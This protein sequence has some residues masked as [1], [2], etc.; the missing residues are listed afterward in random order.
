MREDQ[1]NSILRLFRSCDVT[2]IA[3]TI[4][5]ER[6]DNASKVATRRRVS[7]KGVYVDMRCLGNRSRD[8]HTT[9]ATEYNKYVICK[10]NMIIFISPQYCSSKIKIKTKTTPNIYRYRPT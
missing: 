6:C 8:K 7:L 4:S 9:L 10:Y 1:G 5:G 3:V 2:L